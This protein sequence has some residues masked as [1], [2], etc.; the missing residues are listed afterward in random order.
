L[1]KLFFFVLDGIEIG[2]E[3]L[4]GGFDTYGEVELVV[5]LPPVEV[6][7]VEE[8]LIIETAVIT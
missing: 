4:I 3:F 7:E 5:G 2:D 8:T 6:E 1:E